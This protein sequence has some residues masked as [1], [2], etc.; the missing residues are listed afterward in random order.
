MVAM[1]DARTVLPDDRPLTI[2]DLDLL[3]DDGNKYELDD[4]L[5]VV[6][7]APALRHQLVLTRLTSMLAA[8]A[9][10]DLAVV[11]GPG[12]AMSQIQ[13]REPD[14]AV[15]RFS[16]IHFDDKT[17]TKPPVLVI[18]VASPSTALYDRNRKKDVYAGFGIE[19]YWIVHPDLHKPSIT[20]FE[21]T[22]GEYQ[23]VAEVSGEEPLR[24]V[25]PFACEIVATLL[26]AGPWQH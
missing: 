14:L 12:V 24:P 9:P 17:V 19:S 6:S 3:P 2:D 11:G 13:Y 22:D 5:L 15:V 16:D 10:P 4:G 18:E 20:A 21:L 25:K 7:P 1:T 23:V 8:Q 26:V